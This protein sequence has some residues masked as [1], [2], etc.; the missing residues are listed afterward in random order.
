MDAVGTDGRRLQH[1][2]GGVIRFRPD[3]TGLELF[4]T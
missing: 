1:R 4:A 2:G 3:G